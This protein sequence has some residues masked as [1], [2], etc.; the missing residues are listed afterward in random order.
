M[1]GAFG[2]ERLIV[3]PDTA[4][5]TVTSD[6][7]R[8][9]FTMR[10]RRWPNGAPARV[11]V[12]PDRNPVHRNFAKKVLGVFPH[13]LRRSWDRAVFS[14]TGQAPIEVKDEKQ[15][16]DRVANTPGA[17]GYVSGEKGGE[18]VQFISLD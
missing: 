1:P 12:L 4:S 7:V 15:M 6:L 13:Q 11:F 3:H 5:D 2:A 14:G 9:L 16:L 10:L 8:S 18:R 17:V